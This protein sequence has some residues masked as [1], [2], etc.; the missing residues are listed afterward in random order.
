L[1]PVQQQQEQPQRIDPTCHLALKLFPGIPVNPTFLLSTLQYPS[2]P[3]ASASSS[4]Y[5]SKM[6]DLDTYA[7]DQADH[8]R[9]D[10]MRI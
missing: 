3:F 6:A 4:T 10:G 1:L 8:G 9:Y 7:D 2:F 5:Q